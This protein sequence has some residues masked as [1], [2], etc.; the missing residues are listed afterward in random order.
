MV[1][2]PSIEFPSLV[3]ADQS[4]FSRIDKAITLIQYSMIGSLEINDPQLLKESNQ[5]FSRMRCFGECFKQMMDQRSVFNGMI[6][7]RILLKC[8]HWRMWPTEIRRIAIQLP[9][10]GPVFAEQ[11]YKSGFQDLSTILT[12]TSLEL[13]QIL[14]RASDSIRDSLRI[15]PRYNLTIQQENDHL[16]IL[17]Q[18]L[19]G[20]D[21]D[22]KSGVQPVYDIIA[23]INETNEVLI[24]KSITHWNK[25]QTIRVECPI[26]LGFDS[27]SII[28]HGIDSRFIGLDKR[29]QLFLIEDE[30]V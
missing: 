19:G 4:V 8:I 30:I 5:L 2:D 1:A 6:W 29:C 22:A 20:F 16:L 21:P 11:L 7:S 9:K 27:R 24:H 15:I 18:N 28:V 26:P 3:S 23:G 25:D 12:L 10:I 14:Q 17:V 13:K